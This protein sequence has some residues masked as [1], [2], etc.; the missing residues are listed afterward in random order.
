MY[1][2]IEHDRV[3][4]I[5]AFSTD[6]RI[7]AFHLKALEDNEHVFPP[8]YAA[9]LVRDSILKKYPQIKTALAPLAGLIDNQ[10]MQQLNYDV[11]LKHETPAQVAWNFLKS[12]KLI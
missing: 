2:A 5:M 7:P 12:K 10:T 3:S 11:N 1:S 4:V 9:P 8:Y 6:G